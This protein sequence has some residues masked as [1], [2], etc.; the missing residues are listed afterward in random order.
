M[1]EKCSTS[2]RIE[3]GCRR[4]LLSVRSWNP[5][6]VRLPTTVGTVIAGPPR[7]LCIGPSYWLVIGGSMVAES[8]SCVD[9]SDGLAA[10]EISGSICSD[11]FSGVCALD[12]HPLVF[13]VNTCCRTR[14]AGLPVIIDRRSEGEFDCYV[15]SSYLAYLFAV[16]RDGTAKLGKRSK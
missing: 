4:P 9:L 13:R 2:L 12:F 15:S 1:V 11:L 6:D 3:V 5:T 16:L 8:L 10:V 14:F 7:V